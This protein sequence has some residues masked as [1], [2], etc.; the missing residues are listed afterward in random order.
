MSETPASAPGSEAYDAD[1]LHE[2]VEDLEILNFWE[3]ISKYPD[4]RAFAEIHYDDDRR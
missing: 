2:M 1:L 4:G 3:F